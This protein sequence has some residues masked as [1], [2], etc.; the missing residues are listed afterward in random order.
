MLLLDDATI[1]YSATDLATASSC[2]YALLRGLDAKLGRGE[3]LVLPQDA[4]LERAARLGDVHE[5]RVLAEMVER[6][7]PWDPS[8]GTGVAQVER[9]ER[10]LARDRATLTAKHAETLH[11]LRTGA[12]VVFQAGFFDGRFGGWADF[13]VRERALESAAPVYAVHDT[14]LARHAKVTALLQ[15][16][17]YADQLLAD[18]VGVAPEVHLVLGDRTTTSH[19]LADLLP[20]YRLRRARLE[21]VLDEHQAQPAPVTWGDQRYRACGRC[22]VCAP[23]VERTRDVLLVAGMRSTQ[24]ARLRDVGITTLDELAVSAGTV[25]GIGSGTLERLRAQARLQVLQDPPGG[26]PSE[27]DGPVVDMFAPEVVHAL[28]APDAGDIFFDFEGD[29]LWTDDGVDW[30]LEYLFGVVEHPAENDGTPVFRAFWAHDREEEKQALEDF[31]AYLTDR[32]EQHPGMHVYHYAAY[33]KTALLRLAGRHGVGEDVV[34][35]LLRAGVLVD[36][37]ATVRASLRTGQRSYSLK[38]LEPLFMRTSRSGDVTTADAS[39]TEY[40]DACALRDDGDLDGWRDRLRAIA[41]YNEYDCVATLRLRDWLRETARAASAVAGATSADIPAAVGPDEPDDAPERDD[42]AERLLAF[43]DDPALRAP[44]GSRTADQQAV[45]LLAA[46]LGYHWR[47][48]K[49]FWWGH[50]DRL[51]HEPPDWSEKRGTFVADEVEVL[52]G[53][54]V[55]DGKRTPVRRLR[56]VGRLEPGSDL[57]AGSSACALYDP[58]VPECAQVSVDGR[59]GWTAKVT[60]LDV[61]ADGEGAAVRDVLVVEDGLRGTDAPHD[62]VP[63]ALA[64]AVPPDTRGIAAAIRTLAEQVADGLPA[65]PDHPAIDVLRRRAPRTRAGALPGDGTGDTETIVAALTDL[66]GSYVAVQGPPGTGKSH[67]GAH[68][69]RAL[70]ERGWRVAVVAQ[71]HAVVENLLT[72]VVEAGV[73]PAR[74]GKRPDGAVGPWQPLKDTRAIAAFQAAQTGG[75]VLGGTM[76]DLTN[77]GRVPPDGFDVV[78][79]DEAGQFS[80]ANTVAVSTAGRNLLL[81]GDPQQLPQVSQGRHPEP[82]DRSALGW[83]TDGHDTMPPELGYLLARTWRMHPALTSVVSTLSYDGRLTA[84]PLTADRWLEGVEPGVHCVLLDHEG[85]A[86]ASPEEADEVVAQVDRLVGRRWV[87]PAAGEDRPLTAADVVVVAPYNAQVWT[88]RRALDAAGHGAAQ[89]GTVD[90]FQGQQAPVV[91]VSMTASS[92]DDVPRGMEF[93]LSRN[94]LN[95]AVSRGKWAAVVVRSAALTDHLPHRPE[96]LEELGAF[97]GVCERVSEP[98][99]QSRDGALTSA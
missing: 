84:M 97:I 10:A 52:E 45:A 36:L 65:L 7:G 85:N 91:V 6:L 62:A 22:A 59:R 78:V 50:Y 28:P 31:L 64:P 26:A 56:L 21:Q 71:S 5:A 8:T 82:V 15:L 93:L 37:Y 95:V 13:L 14:K 98:A 92:A 17:A 2:E 47:E 12:D 44:D 35:R 67:T 43:A 61:R 29:P 33:E 23:E 9:P 73:E 88:I 38:K 32:L 57:R 3:D 89:V 94:R 68:V 19:R 27:G 75:Y 48:T 40:A 77:A 99:G 96:Q 76:W 83:L 49:P 74:V 51:V 39:I 34:D 18:D 25:D 42:L 1:V 87:D 20:V 41:E 16:A 86:V 4:M 79:V 69:V 60:V 53:W 80:L 30:G 58:P 90:R 11:A 55:P 54:H 66:D 63:M 81:L 72:K 46:A 70:V 24:R